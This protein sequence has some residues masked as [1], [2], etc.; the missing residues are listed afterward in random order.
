MHHDPERATFT[1]TYGPD[2]LPLEFDQ[3]FPARTILES[4]YQAMSTE[5]RAALRASPLYDVKTDRELTG[6]RAGSAER[7]PAADEAPAIPASQN[8]TGATSVQ[9]EGA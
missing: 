4:E 3:R 8:K 7:E 1:G 9:Q 5:D 6:R 2:G